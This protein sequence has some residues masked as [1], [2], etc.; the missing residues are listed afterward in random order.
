M[1]IYVCSLISDVALTNAGK[2]LSEHF[3]NLL[4][5]DTVSRWLKIVD[6]KYTQYSI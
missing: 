2:N 3:M 6:T 4:N 5:M 1:I